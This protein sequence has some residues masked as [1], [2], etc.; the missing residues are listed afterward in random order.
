MERGRA[1]VLAARELPG[2]EGWRPGWKSRR[3]LLARAGKV[4]L[5]SWCEFRTLLGP[6]RSWALKATLAAVFAA[7]LPACYLL[8]RHGWLLSFNEWIK[9]QG[10][11]G[12]FA[13]AIVDVVIAVLL[14]A[15]SELMWVAAGV[16]FDA[17]GAPLVVVSSVVAS[18]I[19]FLLSRQVLRPKVRLLLANRPLLRAIDAAIGSQSWQVAILLR[20]NALVPFN[21]QNYFFGA[22]DIGL[23]PYTI[24]TLFGI[25]PFTTM[26]VYVGTVGRTIALEEG[27][28]ASNITILLFGLL[29][30][31]GLIYLV[32]RKTKQKLDEMTAVAG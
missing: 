24:T 26:Y 13:F 31:A 12:V 21:F 32:G 11:A 1:E 19:A 8:F 9:T 18:L 29:A 27:F 5:V 4:I 16:V 22:T 17:W 30:T 23:V 20:L 3:W 14:L 28:G 2:H 10:V 6:P 7:A 15:P 25:M